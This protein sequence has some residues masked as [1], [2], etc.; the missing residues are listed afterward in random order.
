[1]NLISISAFLVVG[2]CAVNVSGDY[3]SHHQHGYDKHAA[4]EDVNGQWGDRHQSHQGHHDHHQERVD[5]QQQQEKDE[6]NLA[7][8]GKFLLDKLG[9]GVKK[10]QKLVE[11][12]LGFGSRADTSRRTN[13]FFDINIDG[14]Y[15][16]R[17]NFELFDEVVPKTVDNFRQL[18]TGEPGYGYRGS[19]FHRIIPGFM[20]QGGDFERGDGTGGYSIYG[21]RFRDENF[22]IKHGSPGLLSMAN[23]G[24]DTNGSQ[25][26][27]TTVVTDWLDDKHVVFGRVADQESWD[28]VKQI[29]SYGS[30]DGTP[31]AEIV[32]AESGEY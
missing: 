25:F 1:M 12:V 5:N 7:G 23:A 14:Q 30:P 29:E 17:I 3:P 19:I 2:L 28:L 9:D 8:F 6:P 21:P 11:P 4:Q 13:I 31:S 20:L 26:F 10:V 15:A 24:K 18:A 27:I 16:G 22:S 32:I